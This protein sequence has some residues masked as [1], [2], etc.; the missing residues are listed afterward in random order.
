MN[1]SHVLYIYIY[2]VIMKVKT[3]FLSTFLRIYINYINDSLRQKYGNFKVKT[4]RAYG[5]R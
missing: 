1:R 3:H 2:R 4:G 5:S